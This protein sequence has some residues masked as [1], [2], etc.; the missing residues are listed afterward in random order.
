MSKRVI[1]TGG[2]ACL[3][4]AALSQAGAHHPAGAYLNPALCPDLRED[5]RDARITTSYRD[6]REDRYDRAITRCPA[7][8]WTYPAATG[9]YAAAIPVRPVYRRVYVA[10]RPRY[11]GYRGVRRVRV[12]LHVH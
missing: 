4:S 5:I 10:L 7:S 2:L 6:L 3:A 1:L 12:N 8:A 11:Y 9:V